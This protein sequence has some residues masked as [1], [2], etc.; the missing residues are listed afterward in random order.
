MIACAV[1]LVLLVDVSGS[2]SD[3]NHRLQREGIAAA[4]RDPALPRLASIEG[5]L[6][7]T[8]IEW[9]ANSRTV[10]PWRVLQ[11]AE[12][13]RLAAEA[14]LAPGRSGMG[15]TMM[16]QALRAAI[17]AVPEAPCQADRV[18]IDVSG[19]GQSD[20]AVAE[21]VAFAAA[22]GW[23][24]NGLPIVTEAAPG[25][26]DWYRQNVATPDGFTIVADGFESVARAMRRKVIFEVSLA[27]GRLPAVE[28]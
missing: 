17:A 26:D 14:I 5:A 24:I 11:T 12:D 7:V 23:Q 9:D 27:L 13:F 18:V 10:L 25:V 3:T 28:D 21:E 2:V 20:D 6:A 8:L 1:A 22:A 15:L 16:G 19:D 4:L